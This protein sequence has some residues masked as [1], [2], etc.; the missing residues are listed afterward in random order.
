MNRRPDLG[1]GPLRASAHTEAW[2]WRAA[3]APACR[4]DTAARCC[5]AAI[6]SSFHRRSRQPPATHRV[7]PV[8]R[9]RCGQEARAGDGC[10]TC[11]V[12]RADWRGMASTATMVPKD[13][14]HWSPR[15]ASHLPTHQ[16][17]RWMDGASHVWGSNAARARGRSAAP[18]CRRHAPACR[19]CRRREKVGGRLSS[20]SARRSPR[21]DIAYERFVAIST[22]PLSWEPPGCTGG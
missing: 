4:H 20:S 3:R 16:R 18:S 17:S 21:S 12:D 22:L 15:C 7:Q 8:V 1:R 6:G 19:P 5:L 10:S 11:R 2:A 13:L 9:L 14:S